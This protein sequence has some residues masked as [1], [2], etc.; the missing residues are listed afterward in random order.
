[1]QLRDR[2]LLR[3]I[4]AQH[5]RHWNRLIVNLIVKSKWWASC[6]LPAARKW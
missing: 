5:G 3:N 1:M 6:Y 2:G 4:S